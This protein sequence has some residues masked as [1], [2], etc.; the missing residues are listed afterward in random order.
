M[1]LV[2][3]VKLNTNQKSKNALLDTIRTAN[4]AANYISD[5][6][7][8][9]QTFKKYD[10]HKLV[11][12]DVREQ[13]GLSAQMTV[14]VIAKVADAYKLDKE[15][16]RTFREYGAIAYDSRILSWNLDNQTV[17]IW[18]TQGR[19][20]IPFSAGKHQLELLQSQQG[21]SD[22]V[23]FRDEFY[24]FATCEIE[25]PDPADFEDVLGIDLGI[26]N[27]ATNSDG[28]IYAG[29]ALN[30]K[31]AERKAF[32]K[33]LQKVGTRQAKRLAKKQSGRESRFS[34][35][36]NH[37]ISKQIVNLAQGTNRAIAL[38]KLSGIRGRV[39]VRRNQR[40]GLHS[41]TFYDLQQKIEYKARLAGVRVIYIDPRNTSRTCPCCGHVSKSNR[42][43]Q[44]TFKCVRCG[45]ADHADIVAAKN[46]R[47][48]AV[49]QPYIPDMPDQMA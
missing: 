28:N 30:Q 35:H 33:H 40:Y 10:L 44:S 9:E 19:M 34:K 31:R 37:E 47:Q 16:K 49:T 4:Q 3:K 8:S 43:N 22:L 41:W 27:I 11:Y 17:S 5:I 36:V 6:A 25:E 13:F 26:V 48:V 21:E 24:L 14:R 38:E 46:I 29:D 42:P 32:R 15:T 39:T 12:Y 1:K 20:H 18:T 7:W 45:F 2:A 23:F